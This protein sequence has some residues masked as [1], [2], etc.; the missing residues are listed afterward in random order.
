M[1]RYPTSSLEEMK[2]ALLPFPNGKGHGGRLSPVPGATGGAVGPRGL[3]VLLLGAGFLL[4]AG[5]LLPAAKKLSQK[6]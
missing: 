1:P 4:R 2:M 6:N 3:P 5:D